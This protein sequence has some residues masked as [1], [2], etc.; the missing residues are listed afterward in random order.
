VSV[1]NLVGNDAGAAFLFSIGMFTRSN[2]I[3]NARA[4]AAQARAEQLVTQLRAAQ[5]AGVV[6]AGTFLALT[7]IPQASIAEVAVPPALA[8]ALVQ[9]LELPA[10]REA[11]R[12]R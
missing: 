4:R 2:R 7:Q 3:S 9:P 10:E 1:S 12:S 11:G 5:A 8:G 6:L